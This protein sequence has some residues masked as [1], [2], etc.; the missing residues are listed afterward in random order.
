MRDGVRIAIDLWLPGALD[1]GERVP[2]L[3]RPTRYWRAYGYTDGVIE[4]DSNYEIA[5]LTGQ[6]GYAYMIVD[7]RGAGASFGSRPYPFSTEEIRDFGEILDWIAEQP[8]SNG[9]AGS[10]GVSYNS[11]FA[12][13]I[14]INQNPVL[15][16][17]I[18]Q[19]GD[20]NLYNHLIFPG[21][22]FNEW[23]MK[24]WND[25]NR[26]M[27]AN[28]ICGLQ[29]IEG[30]Q[31]EMMLGFVSGVKPVD[32][33][34]EGLLLDEAVGEHAGNLDVNAAVTDIVFID[35]PVGKTGV[36]VADFSLHGRKDEIEASG[37]PMFI[38]AS[39][40]DAGT[41]DGALSRFFT[42]SN[43]Q[44]LVIGPWSHGAMHHASP[45]LP[46]HATTDPTV[47]RQH[48]QVLN[49]LNAFVKNGDDPEEFESTIRYYTLAEGVW[50]T[51]SEWPPAG[52]QYERWYLGE[53]ASLGT[54]APSDEA[55]SDQYSIDFAATTG[56]TNRWHTQAGGMDVIYPDRAPEDLR[57]L[58]Y[59]SEPLEADTEIT[60]HPIVTLYV[61]STHEDGALYV[62]LEDID[63]AGRVY[64]VTE[65]QLRLIH[66][67]VSEA[68]PPHKVF[69]PYH[70]F[71]RADAMPLTPGVVAEVKFSLMPTS[72]LIRKGHRLRVAIAG[73]DAGN[74][75]RIPSAGFPTIE[76]FRNRVHA[77][78][79]ELP[80]VPR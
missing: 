19:F 57:L 27:D 4:G 51:T 73:H 5:R 29:E 15:T 17:V 61:S 68:E 56:L 26:F 7:V 35:D 32:D 60:G 54:A 78:H 37:V 45:Y 2:T 21:G 77:S 48:L 69:G 75:R 58:T 66:R 49:F 55:G 80:V 72:V 52:T 50:K 13:I 79:I 22:I 12:E 47:T 44:R 23:F 34:P 6:F 9:R 25:G 64:Y 8:W 28:D 59:T 63:E 40:L 18:P 31:C 62:Y 36:M 41:A 20:F 53:S 67:R 39:W 76:V 46:V 65:G 24:R 1:L 14:S 38:W 10:F 33:D 70:S 42:F 43:P 71:K 11:N 16:A 3:I 30:R 74:F